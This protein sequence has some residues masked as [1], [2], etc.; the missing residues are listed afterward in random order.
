M[1]WSVMSDQTRRLA[2]ALAIGFCAVM[3]SGCS[4]GDDALQAWMD[5]SRRN[6]P[7]TV[8]K[9]AEPKVFA[10]FRYPAT[11]E[12]D[13]FNAAKLRVGIESPARNGPRGPDMTRLRE[14]LESY[15]LEAFKMVGNLK[16]GATVV[17]LLKSDSAV[18]QVRV[19]NYIG[20]NFGRIVAISETE[21]AVRESV[22][23]AAGDWV[24]RDTAL[25]L[26]ESG[27]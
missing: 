11:T 25:R 20:Q 21:V 12:V 23:D 13:P 27:K 14:P 8:S 16:Q 7:V 19:G 18:H 6:T 1:M 10:P 22:Q 5:E 9:L 15:S 17:G 2:C 3:V 24:E 4:A 26:Q